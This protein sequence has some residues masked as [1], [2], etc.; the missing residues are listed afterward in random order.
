VVVFQQAH[1]FS[2]RRY[3]EGD[4]ETFEIRLQMR[5]GTGSYTATAE[6]VTLKDFVR[7]ATP[8]PGYLFFVSG[9]AE[10]TGLVDLGAKFRAGS[11]SAPRSA[12]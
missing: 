8:P 7:R 5:L 11:R 6:L 12:S 1:P 4:R 3:K 2:G 9:P 10:M